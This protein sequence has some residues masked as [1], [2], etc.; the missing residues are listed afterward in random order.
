MSLD[1]DISNMITQRTVSNQKLDS[2][3]FGPAITSLHEEQVFTIHCVKNWGGAGQSSIIIILFQL[4]Y[5]VQSN[6]NAEDSLL[7]FAKLIQ[8]KLVS[9]TLSVPPCS[10]DKHAAT[11]NTSNRLLA[12]IM[13]LKSF[14]VRSMMQMSQLLYVF[15]K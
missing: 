12:S 8:S 5:D 10:I 1:S 2:G 15:R 14:A 4:H 13:P 9:L 7:S 3:K 6:C 11:H